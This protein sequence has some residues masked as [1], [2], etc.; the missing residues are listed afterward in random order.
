MISTRD[1][2]TGFLR[3]YCSLKI[4]IEGMLTSW[5]FKS[6]DYFNQLGKMLG[7]WVEF[8]GHR[9]DQ[10]WFK[11][12]PRS[13]YYDDKN[14]FLHIEHENNESR[15][16]DTIKKLLGDSDKPKVLKRIGIVYPGKACFNEEVST[17]SDLSVKLAKKNE[18]LTI[19]FFG[20]MD[21]PD[22]NG[23]W[24]AEIVRKYKSKQ[25]IKTKHYKFKMRNNE[26]EILYTIFKD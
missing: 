26:N 4:D 23:Y 1:I 18:E 3:N 9:Y 2:L 22:K 17:F 20:F 25:V 16:D 21:P 8:E 6:M 7:Y 10:T 15:I 13:K 11:F 5:T 19:M 12:N 14:L 24:L